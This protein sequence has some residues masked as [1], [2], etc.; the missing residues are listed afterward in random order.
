MAKSTDPLVSLIQ[1][2][3]GAPGPNPALPTY[4][5]PTT[6]ANAPQTANLFSGNNAATATK[7]GERIITPA[8]PVELKQPRVQPDAPGGS[9]EILSFKQVAGAPGDPFAGVSTFPVKGQIVP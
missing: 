3:A 8:L 9:L 2:V 1:D 7:E 5:S 6:E 4:G